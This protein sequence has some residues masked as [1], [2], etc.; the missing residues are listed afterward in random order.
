MSVCTLSHVTPPAALEDWVS[1]RAKPSQTECVA[2]LVHL[3][4]E[5]LHFFERYYD[6]DSAAAEEAVAAA[7]EA[8]QRPQLTALRV[9]QAGLARAAAGAQEQPAAKRAR[10]LYLEQPY[11][12]E[13]FDIA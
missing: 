11:A 2:W 4:Q 8:A 3:L 9:A 13:A 6:Q 5:D 12:S 10:V 7:A 1:S